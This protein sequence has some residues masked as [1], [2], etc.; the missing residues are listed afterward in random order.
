MPRTVLLQVS[1]VS[2]PCNQTKSVTTGACA[3]SENPRPEYKG[4]QVSKW[5]PRAEVSQHPCPAC[6]SLQRA[7]LHLADFRKP[8]AGNVAQHL[9]RV[10]DPGMWRHPS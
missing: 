2:G 4:S 9:V 10:S 3:R 1:V 6:D 8:A 5:H 7:R